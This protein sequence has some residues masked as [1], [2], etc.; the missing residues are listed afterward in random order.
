MIKKNN[1]DNGRAFD[2][3][4]TSSDYGKYRDIYP[5]S[6]YNNLLS[7]GIGLKGQ[8]ILDL[9]TGTGVLP[10]GLYKHGANFIGTDISSEQIEIAKK[11]SQESG[12]NIKYYVR[13]AEDTKMPSDYF[14]VITACQC[15]LYFDR[16]LVFPETKRMLRKDGMF[17]TMW[18]AWVPGEDAV[19]SLS[20]E[21]ILKYN[22][23]WK[24]SGYKRLKVD[25]SEWQEYG[26]KVK[27]VV[28]YDEELPFDIDSW[29]GRIRACR[30]IGA[31]LP[32]EKVIESDKEHREALI[33]NFGTNFTVLH[34]ILII[35][36]KPVL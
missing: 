13:P 12:M 20:E 33:N 7:L 3:G 29:A 26:F 18:M 35:T 21:I 27:D 32:K 9:G 5:D 19:S 34:H 24:G 15:F 14:D 25:E 6:F 1:I 17:S 8:N 28:S 30:G 10:R 11:I 2:W 36:A 31:S 23:D 16:K 4:R 22:P